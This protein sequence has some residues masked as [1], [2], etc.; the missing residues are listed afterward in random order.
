MFCILVPTTGCEAISSG[1]TCY[2]YSTSTGI[3]WADARLQCVTRGYDLATI[4]SSEENTL[5]QNITTGTD[6]WIGL[7]DIV[8]EG[9]FLWPDGSSPTYTEW[10]SG[11]PNNLGGED[12]VHIIG[13]DWND[14]P[15]TL[16]LSCYS[17]SSTGKCFL[18]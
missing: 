1:G 3:N 4:S 13:T 11:E 17:C 6:C 7:N 12:C 15:C 9:T 8:N 18:V 5:V 16:T 10:G 14:L 2:S